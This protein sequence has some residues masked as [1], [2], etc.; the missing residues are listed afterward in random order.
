MVSASIPQKDM[1]ELIKQIERAEKK[2]G[3]GLRE[4]VGWAGQ[5]IAISLGAVTKESKKRRKV[6]ERPDDRWK[7]DHRVGRWGT[8]KYVKGVK[9]WVPIYR[10]GEYGK[11]FYRS[12]K[13]A[14]VMEYDNTTG[15]HRPRKLTTGDKAEHDIPGIMQS[16]KLIIGRSGLAKRAW[17]F[18]GAKIRVGGSISENGVGSFGAVVWRDVGGLNPTLIINDDLR[19][20][21]TAL[22]GG[23]SALSSVVGKAARSMG[24]EIN[25]LAKESIRK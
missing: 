1:A 2:L 13:T 15:K 5:K 14:V 25:R 7:T 16:P 9:T 20:A 12:K 6:E 17:K 21:M 10:T 18:L 8:Y 19:Y 23:Q 4:S 11:I 3:K 22:K 24:R